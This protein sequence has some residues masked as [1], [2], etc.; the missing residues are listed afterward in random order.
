MR[1]LDQIFLTLFPV[2]AD[3]APVE[4]KVYRRTGECNSCGKCC[5]NIYLGHGKL[6]I[7]TAEEFEQL[8]R[9]HPDYRNFYIVGERE[10]GLLFACKHL[11][12]DNQ[13]AVYEERP[14]LCRAFPTEKAVMN[15]GTLPSECSYQFESLRSFDQTLAAVDG[16]KRLKAGKLL[17]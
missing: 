1:L 6:P 3:D 8:K 9:S 12:P 5:T 2:P 11:Q 4:G 13:C 10:D 14:R 16:K 7:A 15:G 17:Q